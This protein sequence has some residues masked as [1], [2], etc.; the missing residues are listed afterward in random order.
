MENIIKLV[1]LQNERLRL[2]KQAD[3]EKQAQIEHLLDDNRQLRQ[4]L[5]NYFV[6]AL[7]Q[8]SEIRRLHAER[9]HA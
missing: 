7:R 8:E 5:T 9:E 2:I 4:E 6:K 1:Q 3:S